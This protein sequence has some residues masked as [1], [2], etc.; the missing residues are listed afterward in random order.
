LKFNFSLSHQGHFDVKICLISG[1]IISEAGRRDG[2]VSYSLLSSPVG[3]DAQAAQQI[4]DI[5]QANLNADVV[6][7]FGYI[8]KFVINNSGSTNVYFIDLKNGQ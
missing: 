1:F 4:I 3:P 6:Q 5:I 7:D 2:V 8:Y